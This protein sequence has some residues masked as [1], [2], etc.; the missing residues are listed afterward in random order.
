MFPLVE[1]LILVG[2]T[3]L[4][5]NFPLVTAWFASLGALT[6]L[7]IILFL[8]TP[9]LA[10]LKAVPLNNNPPLGSAV[11]EAPPPPPEGIS[12]HV[13]SLDPSAAE[14]IILLAVLV[15]SASM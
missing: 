7:F 12:I 14:A 2:S 8:V 3:D 4:A 13:N 15:L 11:Y 6:A 1:A 9:L 5:A 10:I